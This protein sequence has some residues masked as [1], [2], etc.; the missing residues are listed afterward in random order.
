MLYQAAFRSPV[1]AVAAGLAPLVLY[2][3]RGSPSVRPAPPPTPTAPPTHKTE[4]A[5]ASAAVTP[6]PAS[7]AATSTASPLPQQQQLPPARAATSAPYDIGIVGGGIVGLAV[8]RECAVRGARVVLLEREDVVAAAASAGNSGLGCT[9]YDAPP[10]SL[11]R[12]LLRRSIRRHPSLYRSFGLSYDHVRKC[13]SLV[14]AWTPEELAKLPD[15]LAENVGAGDVEAVI[16]TAAEVAEREPAL[17]RD[18]LGAV[19]CPREAVVE[20]YLVPLGYAESARLHGADIRTATEAV[21][22]QFDADRGVWRIGTRPTTTARQSGRSVAP[23]AA[24]AVQVEAEA[25]PGSAPA[26][27]TPAPKAGEGRDVEGDP[28]REGGHAAQDVVEARVVVNC[29]G[30]FGDVVDAYRLGEAGEGGGVGEGGEGGRGQ[31]QGEGEGGEQQ[32]SEGSDGGG[33]GFSII[34]RKGQFVVFK[35]EAVEEAAEGVGAGAGAGAGAATADAAASSTS[36]TSASSASSAA[37][38]LELDHIIEP[39]AT[40]FTKGVIAWQTMYVAAQALLFSASA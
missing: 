19:L 14:V 3:L 1:A 17:S 39:V 18:A 38:V 13:G 8:A 25:T 6:T 11:E 4:S 30:L 33:V 23:W 20:P 27:L 12:Q 22:A 7:T 34:P 15:V 35:R 9:G 10:G 24:Q 32:G 37:P 29:A 40:Q 28:A 16:L 31:R 26:L 2:S 36:S 21:C 5:A